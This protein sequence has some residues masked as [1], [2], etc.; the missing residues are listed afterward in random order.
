MF[1]KSALLYS[2]RLVAGSHIDIKSAF[3]SLVDIMSTGGK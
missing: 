1:V 3:G 2:L